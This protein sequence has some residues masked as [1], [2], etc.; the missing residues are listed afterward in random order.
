VPGPYVQLATFCD[1]VLR[2][3]DGVLSVIRAIDRVI[4]SARA[5]G[6]PAELPEG[7]VITST[8]VIALKSDD[9]TGRH[10]VAIRS[11]RPSGQYVPEHTYD[12]TFEG[13]ERGVNLVIEVAISA[14]EGLHWFDVLV[15]SVVLTRVPLRIMYQR[16][17]AA[18]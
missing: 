9:A 6:A 5:E 1:S 2:G 7:G 8:L 13:A 18:P 10:P 15:N 16:V 3:D 11:Q 12:V 4:L 14:I 17:P